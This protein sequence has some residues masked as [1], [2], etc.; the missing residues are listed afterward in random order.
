MPQPL[1]HNSPATVPNPLRTDYGRARRRQLWRGAARAFADILVNH[2]RSQ[3]SPNR[4]EYAL[5]DGPL[6]HKP[7]ELDA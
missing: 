6:V 5:E 2:S 4:Y 3:R 7:V 1:P